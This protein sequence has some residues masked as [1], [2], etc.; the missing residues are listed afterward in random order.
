MTT[1]QEN[2]AERYAKKYNCAQVVLTYAA[3]KMGFDKDC[4]LKMAANF[5]GGMGRG[6]TCGCVSGALMALGLKYAGDPAD[7]DAKKALGAKRV[8]FEKRFLANNPSLL[9][10]ELLGYD[11]SIPGEREKA[12]EAGLLKTECPRFAAEAAAILDELLFAES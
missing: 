5:G 3:D 11:F 4:A 10:K 6:E 1:I 9:C 12:M 8:E 2:I 7:E